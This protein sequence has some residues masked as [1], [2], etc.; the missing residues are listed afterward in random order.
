MPM[1]PFLQGNHGSKD[2]PDKSI[3]G[4]LLGQDRGKSKRTR[5]EICVPVKDQ[6]QS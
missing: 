6:Y 5:K 2:P 3:A 4:N 1:P